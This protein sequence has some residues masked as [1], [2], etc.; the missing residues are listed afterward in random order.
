MNPFENPIL[1]KIDVAMTWNHTRNTPSKVADSI[2]TH[3]LDWA[4]FSFYL[5][6]GIDDQQFED[7]TQAIV[8]CFK[9]EKLTIYNVN[10][11]SAPMPGDPNPKL[12]FGPLSNAQDEF[13][14][15]TQFEKTLEHSLAQGDMTL[16]QHKVMREGRDYREL[17]ARREL[18]KQFDVDRYAEVF[19][20][21]VDAAQKLREN[22]TA[23]PNTK[24]GHT[25]P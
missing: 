9:E 18:A 15:F 12:M 4:P 6:A 19:F 20:K 22:K 3:G 16:R 25:S 8:E 7:L 13:N 24:P 14:Y 11:N 1:A 23:R 10:P 21:I 17:D 2:K 5:F